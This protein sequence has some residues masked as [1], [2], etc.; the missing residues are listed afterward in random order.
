MKALILYI[1]LLTAFHIESP[2]AAVIKMSSIQTPTID[3]TRTKDWTLYYI[4]SKKSFSFSVDTLKNF[5][6][7]QLDQNE[8][9]KFLAT[10]AP[11]SAER[12]PYWMGYYIASCRLADDSLIKIEISQYGRFFYTEK[13]KCYYQLAEEVQDNWMAYLIAKWR[14]LEVITDRS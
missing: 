12:T 10:A 11:L 13:D 2:K 1:I 3:W 6:S 8:M 9:K 4:K 14:T 5:K 7:V